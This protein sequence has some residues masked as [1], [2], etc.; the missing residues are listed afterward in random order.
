MT[1]YTLFA[2]TVLLIAVSSFAADWGQWR[3]PDHT[4][5]SGETGLLPKWAD[6]GPKLLW[7]V[8]DLGAGYSN[9]AFSGGKIFSQGDFDGESVLY[10]LDEKTG[11]ELWSLAVGEAGGGGGY[12]GPRSTPATDGKLVFAMGQFGEFVCADVNGEPL[13]KVNTQKKYGTRVMSMWSF[14][15]S[16]I[17][18]DSL[19]II[20]FGGKDGTVAAFEK[21]GKEA[22]LVWQSTEIKEP[23]AY[24]SVVPLT[25]GGI[26]QC[27][28]FTE[29]VVAGLDV[30]TGK[31]LWQADCPGRTAIC[32][33]PAYD[34]DGD[35]LYLIASSA[36]GTGAR[37]FKVSAANGTF[38]AEQIYEDKTLQSHHG[39]I[40]QVGGYFYLLTQRELVC[41]EPKSGEV[42][43]KDRSV[44][45]GSVMSADGKL[46]LR[47]ESGD[48]V[49]AL[50][51]PSPDGYKEI[52]RFSQ[53]DRS[54]KNSWTY[55][56]VYDGKLYI[57][58]QGL[59]LCYEIK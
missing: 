12:Q 50:V 58:D 45:K 14:A 46:I 7:K 33:D 53:P 42:K 24:T 28:V 43:W 39:G 9:L 20:P 26:R 31:V 6:G 37:G 2:C 49:V 23:A 34:I 57:R 3:G 30:K 18:E 22:K 40:V 35:V 48:G 25:F 15:M 36:Y 17:I 5:I 32:S 38:K 55:P 56:T 41:V 21:N 59:L 54:G 51:D 8:Q 52:S 16:P 19:V 10:A 44:G 27:L 1:R 13:W 4:G 29:K 47:S 11:K